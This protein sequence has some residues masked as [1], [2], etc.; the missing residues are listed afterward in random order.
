MKKLVTMRAALSDPDLLGRFVEGESWAAW[1]ALLIGMF[2]EELN[3]TERRLFERLTKRAQEP[4]Q[5]VEIFVG[6]VGRRGGKS[7]AAALLAVFVA[8]LCDHGDKIVIGERPVV[9]CIAQNQKQASVSF[10]YV[11]GIFESVPALAAMI[12]NQTA[13]SLTLKNGVAIEV[14]AASFRGLRGVTALAVI[15]DESCFW[16]TDEGS[17]N[18]DSEII[19]ALLPALATTGGPLIL[20]SSPYSRRGRTWELY[21]R[22]FGPQGDPL[23]LVAQ[24]SSR[25]FNPS[26]PQRVVDRAIEADPASASAE[27]LGQWRSDLE[28]FVAREVVEAAVTPGCFERLRVHGVSYS[29]FVDPSGGSADDMTL[30]LAHKEGETVIL[31]A[32][33]AVKPPFSPDAVVV[34]FAGVLKS[35]GV[36]RIRGDRYAGEWPREAFRKH[37]VQY[38][39]SEK[40]KSDLYR[41]LLPLLNAGRVDLLDNAKLIS[42]L[43]GLERRT[44]RGGRDSIDH[45]PGGHDDLS[46]ACAGAIVMASTRQAMTINPEALRMARRP[47]LPLR[48]FR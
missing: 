1:K 25:D 38:E 46:N 12:D 30:A 42:Q 35:Y 2:G 6:V 10:G 44:A 8:A 23:V 43:V 31:D 14:R 40:T 3:R 34:E 39:C 21:K 45:P 37:G 16:R 29:A 27:Y 4:L 18:A 11:T 17:A 15:A 36:S 22:H 20:I 24:G 26:L 28:A 7:R 47:S 5:L 33:R 48:A 19:N 13:D 41:E 32:V 9:L